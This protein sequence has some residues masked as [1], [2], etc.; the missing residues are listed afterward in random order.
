M[1]V[2]RLLA[3]LVTGTQDERQAVLHESVLLRQADGTS[4]QG[5]DVVLARLARA[6][7]SQYRLLDA[8]PDTIEVM[9]ELPGVPGGVRFS[10]RGEAIDDRL[11][12]V[13]VEM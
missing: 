5:R 1:F 9:L 3:I 2:A 8:G 11:I 6:G 12:A 13:H 4:C 7:E 10:M